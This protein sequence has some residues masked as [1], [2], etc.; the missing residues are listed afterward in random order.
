MSSAL[1]DTH[2]FMWWLADAPELTK[3]LR[4]KLRVATALFVSAAS[5]WEIAT[6]HRIGKLP[7]G[8][9]YLL[10]R[11]DLR[12]AGIELLAIDGEDARAAGELAWDHRDPFDRM[13]VCQARLRSLELITTDVAVLAFH[14]KLPTRRKRR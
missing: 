2:V 6:K 11:D 10:S 4:E 7:E 8:P 9:S 5:Y 14:D 12:K 13:L 1:L 3:S